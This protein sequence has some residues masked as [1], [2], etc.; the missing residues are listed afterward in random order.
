MFIPKTKNI[1]PLSLRLGMYYVEHS[2]IRRDDN[3]VV[4]V[5]SE[6]R[7]SILPSMSISA[8]IMGPG[9]SITT[10]ALK[11]L[12]ANGCLVYISGELGLPV[13]LSSLRYRSPHNRIT[14][15]EMIT[16]DKKR[17]VAIK[18]LYDLRSKYMKMMSGITVEI[19]IFKKVRTPEEALG[20]EAAFMKKMYRELSVHY[21]YSWSR[22][23][24]LG[25][26]NPLKINYTNHL[27]Y[28]TAAIVIEH[29]GL[30]PDIGVLHGRT[31]GG[32]LVFDVA[33]IFKPYMS[34][35]LAFNH[36]GAS[37]KEIRKIYHER[38]LNISLIDELIKDLKCLLKEE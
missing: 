36:I 29:L 18:K 11:E 22:K 1:I 13:I 25:I 21:N 30:D 2:I 20:V 28:S 9:S 31:Q 32:G 10:E 3:S 38:S 23:A 8:L 26:S 24:D 16:N 34:L 37:N 7:M 27:C 12:S 4:C 35:D 33:D 19:P 17:I 14:Q 15:Y 5:N 6:N